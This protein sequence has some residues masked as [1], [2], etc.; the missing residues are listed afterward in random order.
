MAEVNGIVLNELRM[1]GAVSLVKGVSDGVSPARIDQ[2]EAT[3]LKATT[4]KPSAIDA[5]GVGE[6]LVER[7]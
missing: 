5:R 4:T 2:R 6:D 7:D 3:S 1:V